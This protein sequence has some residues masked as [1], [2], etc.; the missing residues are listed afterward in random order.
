M[1]MMEIK[2]WKVKYDK[3]RKSCT[4]GEHMADIPSPPR[5]DSVKIK[6]LLNRK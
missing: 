6:I 5:Y 2:G 1:I 3:I 4:D